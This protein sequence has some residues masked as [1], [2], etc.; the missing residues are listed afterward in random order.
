M[1][2]FLVAVQSFRILE[3][4]DEVRHLIPCASR[5]IG[6]I[7]IFCLLFALSY[8]RLASFRCTVHGWCERIENV[9]FG[10]LSRRQ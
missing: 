10:D 4:D 2:W 1:P 7:V 5:A 8:C 6:R 3:R 9:Q